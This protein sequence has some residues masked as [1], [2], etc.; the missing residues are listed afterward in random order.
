MIFH[1]KQKK[2]KDINISIDNVQIES[3]NTFNFLGI[4]LYESLT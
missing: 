2:I 3:V 1:R 4:M